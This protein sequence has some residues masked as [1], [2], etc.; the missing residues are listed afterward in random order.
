[1]SKTKPVL[2]SFNSADFK[3][4]TEQG[5]AMQRRAMNDPRSRAA[6]EAIVANVDR[7]VTMRQIREMRGFAQAALANAMGV[8][9]SRITPLETA[10]DMKLSSLVAFVKATGGTMTV[11]VAYPDGDHAELRLVN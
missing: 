4:A 6:Y 2:A 9:Q 3:S 10:D 5:R 7:R 11:T 1:M 8:H